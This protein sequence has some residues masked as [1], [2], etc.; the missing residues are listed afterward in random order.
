MINEFDSA[1]RMT[2]GLLL[3]YENILSRQSNKYGFFSWAVDYSLLTLM[4]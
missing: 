1:I 2:H 3:A 4:C